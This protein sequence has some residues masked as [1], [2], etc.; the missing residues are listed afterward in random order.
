[1]IPSAKSRAFTWWF[2]H[3][4]RGRIEDAFSSVRVAGLEHAREALRAGPFVA[5]SNHTSWWDPLVVLWLTSRVLRADLYALMNAANLR[6]LPFFGLVGA[7]GVDPDAPGDGALAMRE[8]VRL[9]S[10]RRRV[11]WIF[12]QGGE[13]PISLRPL[14]FRRGSAEISHAA[15]APAVPFALR[16]EH[17]ADE[18]PML[19]LRV[20]GAIAASQDPVA[21]RAAHEAAVTG[22][23][24]RIDGDLIARDLDAYDT[25]HARGAGP[26]GALAQRCLSALTRP[27]AKV[28]LP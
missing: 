13:R 17:G 24:D 2:S 21:L 28:P 27:F 4:A 8:A 11:V 1:M 9:L 7:F 19:L 22:L 25:L 18:R 6:R 23:L 26:F 5:V 3:H 10:E 16:Y 14:G 12:A 15:R 20:G